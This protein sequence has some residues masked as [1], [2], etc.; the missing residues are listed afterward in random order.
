MQALENPMPAFLFE[1][2][3]VKLTAKFYGATQTT[4]FSSASPYLPVILQQPN[5]GKSIPTNIAEPI[6]LAE[7]F[8][9]SEA[10]SGGAEA[11]NLSPVTVRAGS[12]SSFQT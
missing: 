6:S 4:I 9:A 5:V 2:D 11:S 8:V 3:C 10:L 1:T 12:G 7:A